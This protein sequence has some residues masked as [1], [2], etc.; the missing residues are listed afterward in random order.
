[1]QAEG[2]RAGGKWRGGERGQ[3]LEKRRKIES[4]RAGSIFQTRGRA[5]E[6]KEWKRGEAE[7]GQRRG[8]KTERK[9]SEIGR[10]GKG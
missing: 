1:M 2:K 6:E 5:W 8:E 10:N 3:E 9:I 7:A 4:V